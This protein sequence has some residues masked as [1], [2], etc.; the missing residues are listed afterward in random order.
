VGVVFILYKNATV[1]SDFLLN[2][3]RKIAK[4]FCEFFHICAIIVKFYS[5][6]AQVFG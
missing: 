3:N 5:T 2:E 6:F 1:K 4:I